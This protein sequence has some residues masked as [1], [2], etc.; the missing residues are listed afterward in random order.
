M[1]NKLP[2]GHTGYIRKTV[3]V[4]EDEKDDVWW[5]YFIIIIITGSRIKSR[6]FVVYVGYI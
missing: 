1:F 3:K 4:E 2:C 5:H 6:T